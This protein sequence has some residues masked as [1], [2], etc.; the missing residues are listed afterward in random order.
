MDFDLSSEQKLLADQA[1]SLLA[2]HSPCA[3]LRELIDADA[4]VDERLWL[5][6][7]QMGFL[8]ANI[9]EAFS[10]LGL[11]E[12]DLGVISQE[13]GRANAATPFFSSIVLAAD[14]IALAGSDAQKQRYLPGL[15]RGD[16]VGCF[17]SSEGPGHVLGRG[18]IGHGGVLS[19]VKQPVADAGVADIAV[20]QCADRLAIVNLRERGVVCTRLASFDQLRPHYRLVFDHA[21]ADFMPGA[22]F[23]ERL[24]DRA[25]VQA[26]FEAIGGADACLEMARAY[27]LNRQI[28]GRPLA[29]YQAIK[30][31]LADIAVA[32][33]LARSNAYFAGWAAGASP[34]DLP[35]A[36]AAA[37]LTAIRAFEMAARENLQM[38]GGLG[39]TF[40]ADCHFYYRRERMHAVILGNR[41]YWADRLVTASHGRE[42]RAP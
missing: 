35:M 20:V 22:G 26:S 39:Y 18:V 33:E 30:H 27:V 10:G 1:R 38:H 25:A 29:S 13:L 42:E 9:S 15:S 5:Q 8:S 19:G 41:G 23:A 24:L 21:P 7:S 14:A 4:L 36:A 17:A 32:I 12:I 11:S 28:F 40:E 31:R 34:E 37:R 16:I 2:Q 3:R 6:L